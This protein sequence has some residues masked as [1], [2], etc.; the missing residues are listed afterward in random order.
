MRAIHEE[1]STNR[2]HRG[3]I[4]RCLR[5]SGDAHLGRVHGALEAPPPHDPRRGRS[6]ATLSNSIVAGSQ[7]S[8]V[9]GFKLYGTVCYYL[10][11]ASVL[12][13]TVRDSNQLTK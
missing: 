8:M 9:D 3:V 7:F 5:P 13:T 6:A 1:E 2:Q 12:I 4:R 10:V 11:I